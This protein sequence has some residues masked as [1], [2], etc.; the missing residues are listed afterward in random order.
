VVSQS[1]TAGTT[2]SSSTMVALQ[3]QASNCRTVPSVVALTV[4]DAVAALKSAGFKNIVQIGGGSGDTSAE[5]VVG[6]SLAPGIS[7]LGSSTVFLV[8]SGSTG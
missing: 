7:V 4:S 8:L 3:V 5:T 6:Q 2:I 1:P